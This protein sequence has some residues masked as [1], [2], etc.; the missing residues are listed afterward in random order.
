MVWDEAARQDAFTRMRMAGGSRTVS[1]LT[2]CA[3]MG[4][5]ARRPRLGLLGQDNYDPGPMRPLR[6]PDP[7]QEWTPRP[8][9]PSFAERLTS[10]YG[11]SNPDK[12]HPRGHRDGLCNP[13]SKA[14]LAPPIEMAAARPQTM[15]RIRGLTPPDTPVAVS[16]AQ[17]HVLPTAAERFF[18]TTH[19]S[20]QQ[21][22]FRSRFAAVQAHGQAAM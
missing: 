11:I 15:R 5:P 7:P 2:V 13:Y 3:E 9:T 8:M 12:V 18:G 22:P 21:Q 17:S 4:V 19:S 14:Q 20:A 16:F 6:I 10:T 1:A